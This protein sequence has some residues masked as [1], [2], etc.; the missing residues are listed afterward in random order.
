MEPY[1]VAVVGDGGVGKSSL[2]IRFVQNQFIQEYD[3][4]IEN[5]YRKQ[6]EVDSNYCV[7]GL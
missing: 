2:V 6:F 1:N 7:L 3:T 4:T 5:N